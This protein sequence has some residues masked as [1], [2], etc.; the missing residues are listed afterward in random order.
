MRP[1]FLLITIFYIS[2]INAFSLK[3]KLIK[4]NP[5]DYVVTEQVGT[6]SV[7]L[8]RT[9]TPTY[10]IL[11]EIDTPATSKKPDGC[12]WKEWIADGAPGHIA[13]TTYLIDLQTEELKECYSR[14]P[15]TLRPIWLPI[16]DPY[17]FL[18]RLLSLPLNKTAHENLKRIGPSPS[19]GELDHRAIW[20]PSLVVEGKKIDKPSMTAWQTRWPHDDSLLSECAIEL[21]FSSLPFPVWIEVRSPHYKVSLRAIDSGHGMVSPYP[22]LLRTQLP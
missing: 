19:P 18:P 11:E 22:I 4:G 9:V 10:M 8:I 6:S 7:L 15:E 5:G 1:V 14:S 13:W 16:N 2:F 12:S 20:S 3:D 17:H 21:Y